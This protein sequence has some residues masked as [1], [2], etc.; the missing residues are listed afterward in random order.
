MFPVYRKHTVQLVKKDTVLNEYGILYIIE[1]LSEFAASSGE[2]PAV[3]RGAS[4]AD[5]PAGV[6]I[7][8]Y[9]LS[10][11]CTMGEII[12]PDTQIQPLR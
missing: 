9:K 12:L 6:V 8:L 11:L 7:L 2:A 4:P 10:V 5:S 3:Y 1:K